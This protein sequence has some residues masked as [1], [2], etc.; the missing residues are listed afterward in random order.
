MKD[1]SLILK[2]EVTR[3]LEMMKIDSQKSKVL[4]ESIVDDIIAITVKAGVKS[5]DDVATKIAKLEKELNIPKGTLNNSDIAKLAKGGVEAESVVVKIVNNLNS[6]D[7]TKLAKKVWG[8]LGGDVHKNAMNI[9]DGLKTSGKKYTSSD[10]MDY[11]NSM[12]ETLIKSDSQINDLVVALRKE[13]VD[14][15]YN[16]L[17][18]SSVI[19]DVSGMSSK[20]GNDV[21]LKIDEII[22]AT[23]GDDTVKKMLPN[24][25]DAEIKLIKDSIQSKYGK[26]T[27][28]EVS[29]DFMRIRDEFIQS[30]KKMTDDTGEEVLVK[31]ENGK[32]FE[33]K[34]A[35]W[36]YDNKITRMCLGKSS[37][38]NI[39]TGANVDKLDPSFLKGGQ[40]ILG[41]WALS[42]LYNHFTSDPN[43]REFLACPVL[44]GLGGFCGSEFQTKNEFCVKS[45]GGTSESDSGEKS[46]T[47]EVTITDFQEFIKN[48]WGTEY[49]GNET[50]REDGNLFIVN[51]GS[52]DFKYAY[53]ND[54]FKYIEE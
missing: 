27:I 18:T 54:T 24:I 39:K 3:I 20:I 25:S 26:M 22:N 2:E 43:E 29:S 16:S 30:V 35:K 5:T 44:A 45:C 48:D 31:V 11:L 21:S 52:Q 42:E 38:T 17:K 47:N 53:K 10:A 41:I 51:D 36:L 49:T 34:D 40:C 4:N 7:L 12:S 1:K 33:I 6:T 23:L 37:Y 28:D 50:F 9:I 14:R 19:D 13:F 32:K 8:Q 15:S 46:T